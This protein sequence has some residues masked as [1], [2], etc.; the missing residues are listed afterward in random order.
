MWVDKSMA[1]RMDKLG[2]SVEESFQGE[3][4]LIKQFVNENATAELS[5]EEEKKSL[6]AVFKAVAE[7]TEPI[8]STLVK[9]V[10]AEHAKQLKSLENLESKIMRA[11]KQK[12][13]TALN[14]ISNLKDKLYPQNDG[15][16]ERYD[17]FMGFYLKYGES[18]F[19][20]LK[21]NLDPM[22]KGFVVVVDN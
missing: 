13:E 20:V 9:A 10:W 15:L 19:E 12:H 5:L 21:D 8:E 3:H 4:D 7:K 1:K 2:L 11:E 16:Q 22:K 17:N 6:E 18:F 14:R